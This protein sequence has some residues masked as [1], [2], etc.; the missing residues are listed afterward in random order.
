MI[1]L[2]TTFV[3]S[4]Q[5]IIDADVSEQMKA[6]LFKGKGECIV[7]VNDEDVFSVSPQ[8]FMLR[9]VGSE[10]VLYDGQDLYFYTLD[11]ICTQSFT[12]GCHVRHIEPMKMKVAVT[13]S[14]QGVYDDPIGKDVIVVVGK[15]GTL[16][17]QRA[18]AEQHMLQYDICMEKVKPYACLSY[19]NNTIIHFNEQFELIKVE[20]CP[21]KAGNVLAMS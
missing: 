3:V 17:S 5:V 8:M 7:S 10:L 11:G 12:I 4:E 21:F 13:Y 20:Q 2:A 15:D 18:F 19:E 1:L 6:V 14:D 9:I 16:T